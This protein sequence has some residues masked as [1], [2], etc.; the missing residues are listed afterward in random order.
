MKTST[1]T[2]SDSA[3]G[4]HLQLLDRIRAARA[5]IGDGLNDVEF[6]MFLQQRA[7]P[8]EHGFSFLC[9]ADGSVTLS[10]PP[11]NLETWYPENGWI[12]PEKEQIAKRI[13]ARH[14]ISF[15]EPPDHTP[16][17]GRSGCSKVHHHIEMTDGGES[18]V[19]AH[20]QYLKIRLFE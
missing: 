14:G 9:F 8:A 12:K 17:Y 7:L 16:Q 13:A 1:L 20:P 18:T 2:A 10:V 11:Q 6:T 5:T 19:V 4:K 15:C 3:T